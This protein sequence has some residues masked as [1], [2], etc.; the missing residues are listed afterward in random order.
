M[1]CSVLQCVA[2]CC[3]ALQCAAV[4]CSGLQRIAVRCSALQCVAYTYIY[5]NLC[6]LLSCHTARPVIFRI[7]SRAFHMMRSSFCLMGLFS[8]LSTVLLVL[9]RALFLSC[10]VLWAV[11]KALSTL[12]TFLIAYRGFF[13][14]SRTLSFRCICVLSF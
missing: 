3:S 12:C 2:V 9:C 14:M 6:I 8:K 5:I 7:I 11:H 1:C 4:S 13:H 10:T